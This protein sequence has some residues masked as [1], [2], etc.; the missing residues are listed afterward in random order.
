[1]WTLCSRDPYLHCEAVK[2]KFWLQ[3]T[4]VTFIIPFDANQ[5]WTLK[6][7]TNEVSSSNWLNRDKKLMNILPT[8][9]NF[10]SH[11]MQEIDNPF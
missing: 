2:R 3:F 5:R 7:Y 1:M 4:E 9:C 11:I 10:V 6:L 8:S